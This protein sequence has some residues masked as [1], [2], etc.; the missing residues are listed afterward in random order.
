MKRPVYR[1]SSGWQIYNH[2]KAGKN[3]IYRTSSYFIR[4]LTVL[5]YFIY[6]NCK[7]VY[8]RWQSIRCNDDSTYDRKNTTL[9]TTLR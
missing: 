2:W 9:K 6:G 1:I 8:G 4:D 3:D 5:K 7:S